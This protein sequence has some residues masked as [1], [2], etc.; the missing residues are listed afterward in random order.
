M[1]TVITEATESMK[2]HNENIIKE[3]M[4]LKEKIKML[5]DELALKDR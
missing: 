4:D 3:N 5:A 2:K 1:S